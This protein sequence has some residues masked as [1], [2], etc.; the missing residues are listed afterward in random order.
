MMKLKQLTAPSLYDRKMEIQSKDGVKVIRQED[1]FYFLIDEK[2]KDMQYLQGHLQY[3]VEPKDYDRYFYSNR[4]VN[5]FLQEIAVRIP[6][7]TL[8]YTI[9]GDVALLMH[10]GNGNIRMELTYSIEGKERLTCIVSETTASWK[11]LHENQRVAAIGTLIFDESR[12]QMVFRIASLDV[13]DSPTFLLKH[14][15]LERKLYPV[16]ARQIGRFDKS[17]DTLTTIY[18]IYNNEKTWEDFSSIIREK[19]TGIHLMPVRIH[20]NAEAISYKIKELDDGYDK[21]AIAIIRGSFRDTYATLDFSSVQLIETLNKC[22]TLTMAGLG[23][24]SDKPACQEYVDLCADTA[25]ELAL[26][27]TIKKSYQAL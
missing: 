9:V 19:K 14:L 7:D 22:K 10:I 16:N 23:H 20:F 17:I 26:Q 15:E 5:A 8:A 18:V 13:L 25:Q 6:E 11:H 24:P 4:K 12:A 2:S 21:K 1:G 27:I 3:V